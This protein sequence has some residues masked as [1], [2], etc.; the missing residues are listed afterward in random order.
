[1]KRDVEKLKKMK[2]VKWY[3]T[4]PM[5]MYE[6]VTLLLSHGFFMQLHGVLEKLKFS[7]FRFLDGKIWREVLDT[8]LNLEI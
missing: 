7:R 5:E 4:S 1:V 2:S 8:L 6:E 3:F